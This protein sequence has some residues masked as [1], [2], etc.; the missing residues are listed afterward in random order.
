MFKIAALLLLPISLFAQQLVYEFKVDTTKYD[1]T[2]VSTYVL[3]NPITSAWKFS[4]FDLGMAGGNNNSNF[5]Y[6]VLKLKNSNQYDIFALAGKVGTVT[7]NI[8]GGAQNCSAII[9]QTI[10]DN[11]IGW[12][13]ILN[14]VDTIQR[15][16]FFKIVD[17]NNAVLLSDSGHATY[18]FDGQ[19]TYVIS[20]L[21]DDASFKIWKFRSNIAST[22]PGLA[23]S[24]AFSAPITALMPSG[25]LQIKLA[26]SGNGQISIQLIDMLGRLVFSKNIQDMKPRTS[27][28]IPSNNVPKSPFMAKVNNGN[29]VF[30][31]KEVPAH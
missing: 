26:P 14:Y 29:G 8:P 11:D 16:V 30:Y 17:D 19:S 18:G 2:G 6:L 22:S 7:I 1:F 10:L 4:Q 28:L 15:H 31:Q 21:D 23:K 5:W 12:E 9:S 27:Y 24:S 13:Y 25:D 3:P 20:I